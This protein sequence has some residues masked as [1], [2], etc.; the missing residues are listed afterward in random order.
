MSKKHDQYT[1]TKGKWQLHVLV[2]V[3][4]LFLF[5]YNYIPMFGIVMGFQNYKP[6]LGV[7]GSQWVG[8]SNFKLLFSMRGFRFAVRNSFL[9]AF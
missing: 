5:V 7:T 3:P 8:L 9:I 2:L 4:F 1:I 6:A